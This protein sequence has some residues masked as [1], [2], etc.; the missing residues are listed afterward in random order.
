MLKLLISKCDINAKDNTGQTALDYAV[1][2]DSGVMK[3][4][5]EENGGKTY[6]KEG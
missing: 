6:K 3:K 5:L 4:I 1:E 2:Q